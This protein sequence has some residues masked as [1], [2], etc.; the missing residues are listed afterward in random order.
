MKILFLLTN[1]KLGEPKKSE[2]LFTV[3]NK[4]MVIYHFYSNNIIVTVET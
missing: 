1:I 3:I 4:V 2:Y